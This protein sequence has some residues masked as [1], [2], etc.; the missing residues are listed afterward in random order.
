M[1]GLIYGV[2]NKKTKKLEKVGSTI[3][4]LSKREKGYESEPWFSNHELVKI[5]EVEHADPKFFQL[6]LVTIEALEIGRNKCWSED[7]GRNRMNPVSPCLGMSHLLSEIGRIGGQKSKKP[8]KL[9]LDRAAAYLIKK[10]RERIPEWAK[11]TEGINGLL[12]F[13]F[14][15]IV[16][17]TTQKLRSAR[18]RT[19]IELY[20][21]K[22][23]PTS[24]LQ[25]IM[26][27]SY[28][29]VCCLLR[30]IKMA[31]NRETERQKAKDKANSPE[32]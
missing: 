25:E 2:I 8:S 32:G 6:L 15:D 22:G 31:G 27:L 18:W 19:A 13:V 10:R 30:R 17:N 20:H 14:P 7:G 1:K 29:S 3:Q 9:A 12:S 4:I 16:G 28:K 23:L 24:K 11:T 26:G 21:T 5:R